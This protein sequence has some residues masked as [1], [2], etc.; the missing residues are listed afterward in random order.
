MD[1]FEVKPMAGTITIENGPQHPLTSLKTTVNKTAE[2]PINKWLLVRNGGKFHTAW[3]I[4]IISLALWICFSVPIQIAFEPASLNS[5]ANKM[6][7]I[8]IDTVFLV[9]IIIAFRTTYRSSLS[10]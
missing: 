6:F 7:N 9:D 4:L 2:P 10:S 1:D 3:D 8:L 5:K